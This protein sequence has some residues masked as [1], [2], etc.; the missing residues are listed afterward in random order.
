MFFIYV[1]LTLFFTFF[2]F[3]SFDFNDDLIGVPRIHKEQI[4]ITKFLGSG[5][6]GEVFEGSWHQSDKDCL[7]SEKVAIK[8]CSRFFLLSYL[9]TLKLFL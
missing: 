5:A 4:S 2:T 8:V 9:L 6:F 7:K 1:N 3:N